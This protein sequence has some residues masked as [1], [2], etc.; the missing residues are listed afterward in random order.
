MRWPVKGGGTLNLWSSDS[1]GVLAGRGGG[2]GI[3]EVAPG[4]I[5][6]TDD[7][8]LSAAWFA[9][10]PASGRGGGALNLGR[11]GDGTLGGLAS[12]VTWP[13][14]R[15]GAGGGGGPDLLAEGELFRAAAAAAAAG[16]GGG[17]ALTV[18]DSRPLVEG[19][20]R[21]G[22]G[23]GGAASLASLA[24][25]SRRKSTMNSWLSLIKSSFKPLSARSWPKCSRQRGS[26]ASNKANSE[27]LLSFKLTE[28]PELWEN[29]DKLEVAVSGIIDTVECRWKMLPNRLC[30]WPP[31]AWLDPPNG[32]TLVA[33]LAFFSRSSIFLLNCLASFS[34]TKLSAA[35]HS[36]NSKVWKKVR[37]WL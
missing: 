6:N 31:D 1:R 10:L 24:C 4:I 5:D 22:G 26:K 21:A 12:L 3:D 16:G 27:P 14:D 25:S 20:G 18:L 11:G 30:F 19:E 37:S 7:F 33:R 13:P 8:F 15:R 17:G 29:P 28:E 9:N 35:R 23:G 32:A 2:G 34:S 36:S